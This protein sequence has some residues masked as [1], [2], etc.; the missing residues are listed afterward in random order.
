MKPTDRQHSRHT[1]EGSSYSNINNANNN[2]AST[3]TTSSSLSVPMTRL[4]NH[5]TPPPPTHPNRLIPP[6]PSG[7]SPTKNGGPSY[8]SS[9]SRTGSVASSTSNS[10]VS[11]SNQK[12]TI[13]DSPNNNLNNIHLTRI[14]SPSH[15]ASLPPE[16]LTNDAER[17]LLHVDEAGNEYHY[18]L[19]PMKK[20]VFFILLVEMLERFSF[21]GINYTTTAYL[22]GEYNDDWNADLPSILASSY[23]SISTAVAYTT[24]FL[25]ALLADNLFGEYLT[26]ILATLLCYIPGLTL[27]AL[28][29]IPQFLGSEFNLSAIRLGLLVL[30]PV[31]TGAVKACVNVFG[32]KQFHPILQS[33]LIE[34]YY[35]NFYM[36]INI[37]ALTG[38]IVV[39]IVAQWNVTVAYFIPVC[40]LGIG[41][42]LFVSGTSRYVRPKPKHDVGYFV[43]EMVAA[44]GCGGKRREKRDRAL[45]IQPSP[46]ESKVGIG[47]IFM[48]SGLVVPFNVAYAQMSTTFIV[49]GSVMDNYGLF[50]A[51]MMNNVDAL[52]ILTFGYVIGNVIYPALNQRGIKIPTT[53]KFAIGSTFGALA[54]GCAILTDYRIHRVYNETGEA[55]TVL[56]QAFPYFL[57]GM[58]EIFAVSA[59]YE[60]AFTVAPAKMK[61]VAS[62]ANLFMVGGLPNVFC[63]MLY[64]LCREWFLNARGE[65]HIHKLEDYASA[66]VTNYFWLL[67][68]IALF[69][70]VINVL[71]PVKKWVASIEEAAAETVKSPMSTPNIRRNLIQRRKYRNGGAGTDEE[72]PLIRAE[73]HADYLKCG[74][75]PEL[76]KFGSMRAGPSL[77]KKGGAV[78]SRPPAAPAGQDPLLMLQVR[79][80]LLPHAEDA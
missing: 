18:F 49:Q 17:P 41:V 44:C 65:A 77:K 14:S 35:V 22:T 2:N 6:P 75:G 36:C 63:I 30:W 26:M 80:E 79:N 68:G 45:N 74:N 34:S 66:K 16:F 28:T 46:T 67:E 10:N 21:Y 48:L 51:P 23:V 29:T 9:T 37:G 5:P 50:D 11:S 55:I 13:N 69:G 4:D 31:G 40:M 47:S 15:L 71:P 8:S 3:A 64:N 56:W 25:G 52:S 57:I 53:Y 58:G 20:A 19:N 78:H 33:S 7:S 60:L 38:G 70:I 76:R 12:S 1:S 72:T 27:I 54:V 61:S 32:A 39:P 43:H 62:A 73:K 42:L 59:A 24:P